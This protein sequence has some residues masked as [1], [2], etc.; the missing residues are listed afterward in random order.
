MDV[1]MR[2]A[3]LEK[4]ILID[5]ELRQVY[6]LQSFRAT[7]K[8]MGIGKWNIKA[9]EEIANKHGKYGIVGFVEPSLL[10]FYVSCGWKFSGELY[11]NNFIV[12]SVPFGSIEVHEKW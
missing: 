10:A 3:L 2:A 7:P 6:G 11:E 4:E 12:C 8:R 1:S 9:F 5:G